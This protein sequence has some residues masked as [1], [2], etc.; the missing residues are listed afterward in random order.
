[1]LDVASPVIQV[2]TTGT[3]WPAMAAVTSS[4][5]VGLAG[6][7]A[8]IWQARRTWSHEDER[9]NHAEKQRIYARSDRS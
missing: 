9:G 8:A 4:G 7:G 1:M 3:G 5:I 6:I 2:V